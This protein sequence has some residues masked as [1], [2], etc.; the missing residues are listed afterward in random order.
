MIASILSKKMC[1]GVKKMVLDIPCGKGTKFPTIDDGRKFAIR[2]KDIAQ[3]VG[4]EAICLL[5][6]ASQPIGHAV[7]PALEAKEAMFLLENPKKGST[8]LRNKS[9]ELAGVLLEMGGKAPEGGGNALALEILNSGKA[10]KKMREI[11]KAQ[12]GNPDTT[13]EDIEI[14]PHKVEMKATQSGFITEIENYHIN[15]IAKIAGCP[16][17]KKS[18]VYVKYKKGSRVKEGEVI[19]EIY[20]DSKTRLEE[21]IK[22]YNQHPPQRFSG[23]TIEKI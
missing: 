4:I 22:Y 7:G 1:M 2:F 14:G 11:I 18:G 21:A 16:A 6:D 20:S 9:T 3:K 13:W 23:M 15:R 10:L 19:F 5:T 12:G 17:A 8:S